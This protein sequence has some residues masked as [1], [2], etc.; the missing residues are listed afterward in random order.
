MKLKPLW[1][2]EKFFW[3]LYYQKN[4]FSGL[5]ENAT[6]EL[7]PNVSL[8]LMPTDISHKQIAF[9]G[10]SELLPSR[11]VAQLAK[12][13]GLMVD[14]GANYGY[15][16]CIWAA[17]NPKNQVIAFEAS[18]RNFSALKL[19]LVNNGLETQVDVQQL[20]VGKECGSLP[21]TLG[22]EEQSSWGGLLVDREKGAIEVPVVSL[23]EI[24]LKSHN[25]RIDV[26]KID[27]EGA[28]T[29]VLQGAEQLLRRQRISHI[30][31]EENVVRMSALGLK[32][33]DAQELLQDCGY[34]LEPLGPEQWYARI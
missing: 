23:D 32:L 15:Y 22:S 18:P 30:F 13:G 2:R 29:W 24:F 28:D 5:F 20:A 17:A 25:E 31:F 21:F 14:V 6:L 3:K 12:A 11:R 4:S 1:L 34:R 7:A 19:N 26:L 33:K 8:K 10:F 27:V 9:L 16:S